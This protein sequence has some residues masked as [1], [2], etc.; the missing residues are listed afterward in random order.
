M[1]VRSLIT[2]A[3][4]ADAAVVLVSQLLEGAVR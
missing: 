4:A 2:R 1:N 3:V